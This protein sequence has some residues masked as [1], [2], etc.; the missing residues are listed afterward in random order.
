MKYLENI[1]ISMS[2]FLNVLLNI[3][4]TLASIVFRHSNVEFVGKKVY[5]E[6]WN[7]GF[8]GAAV[9]KNPAASAGD[10]RDAGWI[11][12]SG[13]PPGVG[14]GSSPQ[15]YCLENTMDR[16]ACWATVLGSQRV[17]HN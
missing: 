2:T 5:A 10:A 6:V 3:M 4:L 15:Y 14:N 8:P 1:F 17:G 7:L 11:P 12:G 16:E 13:R 9:V